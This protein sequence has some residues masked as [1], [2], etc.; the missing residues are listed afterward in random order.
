VSRLHPDIRQCKSTEI[1]EVIRL[2]LIGGGMAAV[3]A[4]VKTRQYMDSEPLDGNRD[5]AY[6][7]VLAGLMRLHGEELEEAPPP[8]G[9]KKARKTR[10]STSSPSPEPPH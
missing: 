10:G 4:L 5:V 9:E 2:G 1:F 3:N 7:I 8:S 6:A